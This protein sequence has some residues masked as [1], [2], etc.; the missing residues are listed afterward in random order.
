MLHIREMTTEDIPFGMRLKADA[1]WNQLEADWLRFLALRPG[2]SFVALWHDQPVGTVTTCMFDD[3]GW[4]GMMLVDVRYRGQ[5]IGRGL[6]ERALQSLELS[7]VK[8]V[9]LDATAMGRPLYQKLGFQ[10]QYL[11]LRYGGQAKECGEQVRAVPA[12]PMLVDGILRLDRQAVGVDRSALVRR[13]LEEQPQAGCAVVGDQEMAGYVCSRPGACARQVGPCIARDPQVG[14]GLLY[15]IFR[16]FPH[17]PV[18]VDVPAENL[19]AVEA[20]ESAGLRPLRE[21]TR[22]CRGEDNRERIEWLWA[23]SG[24][25]KG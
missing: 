1:G 7:G 10:D 3:V 4:I 21:L 25:E 18:Y 24:P 16:R 23:S 5:G 13:L 6:I 11:V 20:A 8:S 17:E 2:G 12:E 15:E 19:A 22:M 9:R 14:R